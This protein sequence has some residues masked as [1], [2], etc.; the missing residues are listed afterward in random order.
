MK[1]Y[2]S[3][4]GTPYTGPGSFWSPDP[5][6]AKRYGKPGKRRRMISTMSHGGVL[7]VSSNEEFADVLTTAGV[8]DADERVMDADWFDTDVYAA[9]RRLGYSWVSR[10]VDPQISAYDIEWIYV[11]NDAVHWR[12]A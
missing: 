3:V 12:P 7:E 5:A 11:G 4:I 9:L 1:L 10:P 8:K 6:V 2:R